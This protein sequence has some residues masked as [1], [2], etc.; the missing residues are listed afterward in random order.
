[1]FQ[2]QN[3]IIGVKCASWGKGRRVH[4][5]EDVGL[6]LSD[7]TSPSPDRGWI[8]WMPLEAPSS[9]QVT[10]VEFS[11][12]SWPSAEPALVKHAPPASFIKFLF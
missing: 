10:Q 1:M 8:E 7:F 6:I 11:L 3:K 9:S 4:D 5:R 12:W 2:E